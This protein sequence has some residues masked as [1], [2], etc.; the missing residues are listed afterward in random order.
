MTKRLKAVRK[1]NYPDADSMLV[2]KRMGGRTK[3]TPEQK[4]AFKRV[5]VESGDFCD[6]LPT[7][8]KKGADRRGFVKMVDAPAP[9]T[10]KI[11]KKGGK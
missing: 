7:V 5:V 8:V 6:D 11:P 4:A 3:L 2:V 9:K 10:T 1:F